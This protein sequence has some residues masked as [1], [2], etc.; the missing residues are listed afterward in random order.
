MSL[1]N[2]SDA[3]IGTPRPHLRGLSATVRGLQN[4]PSSKWDEAY[5]I[6]RF[7]VAATAPTGAGKLG[8][9]ATKMIGGA[10]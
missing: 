2:Q 9:G 6:N 10:F 7:G 4:A 3:G 8:A 1:T 5:A